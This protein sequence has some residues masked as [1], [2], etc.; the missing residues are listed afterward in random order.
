MN[1]VVALIKLIRP[2]NC[3]MV[4]IAVLVGAA[5]STD[6]LA[7]QHP[8]NLVFGFLTGSLLIGAVMAINDYVDKEI[9]AINE[10]TRPIPSGDLKPDEA[11]VV[12]F[13]LTIV[14]I[15][16]AY[17]TNLQSLIFSLFAWIVSILYVVK[18][19]RMG[20]PGNLMVSTC[21]AIPFLYGGLVME[22]GLSPASLIFAAIIFLS[23]TAR[24]IIKGIV[25]VPGDKTSDIRT[26]AVLYGESRA[27]KISSIFNFMAILLTPLPWL[28]HIVSI[29]FLPIV[30]LTDIGLAWT[31]ISLLLKPSRE[32][33]RR[34]KNRNLFWFLIGLLAF[35]I[36]IFS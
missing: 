23:N 31:S 22:R 20:L 3:L 11:L 2:V 8:E 16:L 32:N 9:D 35:V 14:G 4:G 36:G 30:A 33:A 18:G 21:V 7:F 12:F 25:D 15:A 1:K 24:E 13:V 5:L 29:W 10:P 28:L 26:I 34:V 27:A 19:K 6:Q 17:L